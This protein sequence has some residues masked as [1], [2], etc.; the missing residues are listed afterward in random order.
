VSSQRTQ[1]KLL[2][3]DNTASKQEIEMSKQIETDHQQSNS[4]MSTAGMI[5]YLKYAVPVF[6]NYI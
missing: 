2:A 5:Q 3:S 4:K 6:D 1:A